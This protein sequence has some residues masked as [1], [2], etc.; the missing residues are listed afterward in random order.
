MRLRWT[1]KHLFAYISAMMSCY[2]LI[3]FQPT[4][5]A[6]HIYC[7]SKLRLHWN[8][9]QNL[10]VGWYEKIDIR[11]G[12]ICNNQACP[13]QYQLLCNLRNLALLKPYP[14]VNT[15]KIILFVLYFYFCF[16]DI[17]SYLSIFSINTFFFTFLLKFID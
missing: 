11:L 7:S 12:Y 6:W 9:L 5:H 10:N 4:I 1:G 13:F 2:F 3:I 16:A 8:F 14:K 15:W 17:K